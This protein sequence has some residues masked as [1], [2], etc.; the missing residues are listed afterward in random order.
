V[1]ECSQTRD[2]AS[3]AV[4]GAT[5]V[6]AADGVTIYKDI[7]SNTPVKSDYLRCWYDYFENPV[8]NPHGYQPG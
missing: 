5:S 7:E 6:G 2:H 8:L 3:D 4:A 1:S